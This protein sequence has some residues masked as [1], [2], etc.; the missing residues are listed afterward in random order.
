MGFPLEVVRELRDSPWWRPVVDHARV[1]GLGHGRVDDPGVVEAGEVSLDFRGR[2]VGCLGGLQ[3]PGGDGG[4]LVVGPAPG[5]EWLRDFDGRRVN[6]CPGL[7]SQGVVWLPVNRV[8][9]DHGVVRSSPLLR[10]SRW[11]DPEVVIDLVDPE[12]HDVGGVLGAVRKVSERCLGQQLR[13]G[14]EPHG[15]L[16]FTIREDAFPIW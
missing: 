14:T 9:L 1:V 3:S 5:V 13:E 12:I 7:W 6:R 2:F 11:P 4:G 15:P 16:F 10:F 8:V